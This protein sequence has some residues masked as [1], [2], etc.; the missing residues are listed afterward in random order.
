MTTTPSLISA[1]SALVLRGS[2]FASPDEASTG[3][4]RWLNALLLGFAANNLGGDLG[5]RGP[6]SAAHLDSEPLAP[7]STEQSPVV[8]PDLNS[9]MV[10][11]TNPA[12]VFVKIDVDT[13]TVNKS[14]DYLLNAVRIAY[15]DETAVTERQVR[16]FSTYSS[17]FGLPPDARLI[18][19]V[20]AAEML[21]DHEPRTAQA[22]AYVQQWIEAVKTSEL[23]ADEKNS[24]RGSLNFMLN[25]SIGQSLAR[26]ATSLGARTYQGETPANFVKRCYTLRSQLVHGPELPNW[27][28]VS[29]RGRSLSDSSAI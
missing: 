24:L 5:L 17:S 10:F 6:E 14:A 4:S 29:L 25:E 1:Q 27:F 23:P 8:L 3:A 19:L 20:S 22:R 9:L 28:E 12:P 18:A 21:L 11:E 2:G 26:L 7:H 16:A 15:A 13:P